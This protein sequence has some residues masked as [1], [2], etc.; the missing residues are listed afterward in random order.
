MIG[1][2]HTKKFPACAYEDLLSCWTERISKSGRAQRRDSNIYRKMLQTH[3]FLLQAWEAMYRRMVTAF[4]ENSTVSL[5]LHT[6]DSNTTPNEVLKSHLIIESKLLI[7]FKAYV[8]KVTASDDME[9]LA[10]FCI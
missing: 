4:C 7:K 5:Q 10:R 3:A 2:A 6:I 9:I 1:L 8:L